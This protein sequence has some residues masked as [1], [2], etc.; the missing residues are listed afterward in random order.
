MGLGSERFSWG[1]QST[2]ETLSCLLVSLLLLFCF[3]ICGMGW[4]MG[5]LARCVVLIPIMLHC[6]IYYDMTWTSFTPSLFPIY[7]ICFV[8]VY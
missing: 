7:F 1:K 6:T 4:D 2:V 8:D 3:V 5:C